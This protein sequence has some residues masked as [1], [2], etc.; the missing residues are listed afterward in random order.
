MEFDYFTNELKKEIDSY[1]SPFKQTFSNNLFSYEIL[2]YFLDDGVYQI[3]VMGEYG[4]S[5][6]NTTP[7]VLLRFQI[8]LEFQQVQLSN[9]FLPNFMKFNGIGKTLIHKIFVIAQE[10]NYDLFITDMV[11]SFYDRMIRRG[12]LPCV[13][14][15]DAV[16]ITD[17]TRL[18]N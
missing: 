14:C 18:S 17:Q 13:D 8:S 11:P 2:D 16:K 12:A 5:T 1:L 4:N 15:D 10:N 3:E 6:N 7:F 9:I